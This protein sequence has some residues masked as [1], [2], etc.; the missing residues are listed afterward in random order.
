MPLRFSRTPRLAKLLLI[1]VLTLPLVLPVNFVLINPGEGNPLFPK[2]LNI[3]STSTSPVAT[4]PADGQM[5]LLSIWVTNPETEILGYQVLQCWS[6]KDCVVVPRSVIYQA[7]TDDE[8]E[9]AQG[10]IEMAK[11]Q[12]TA[13]LATKKLFAKYHSDIDLTNLEDSSI[14]ISLKNTGGPSGGLIFALGL[15]ELLTPEN[16]LQGRKIAATGTISALGK[17]GAIGGVEEKI[18]AARK[19]GTEI[20]F[21]SSENCDEV[22]EKVEGVRVIAVSTLEEAY[23]EL[24]APK[25]SNFQGVKGCTNLAS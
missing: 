4:Y 12:S 20:I 18:T 13:L 9:K 22:P 8:A 1:S 25:N 17:V 6:Q 16:I 11:S 19:T 5:Y 7:E 14:K 24:L 10:K 23:K 21:I 3:Q 15:T 2:L